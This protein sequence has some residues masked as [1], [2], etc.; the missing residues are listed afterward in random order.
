MSR[1]EVG[2]TTTTT[3]DD[4]FGP[5]G[6]SGGTTSGR[7]Q[8]ECRTDRYGAARMSACVIVSGA[9]HTHIGG[10]F[11]LP[12]LLKA[13]V[14]LRP[15]AFFFL[16]LSLHTRGRKR[17]SDVNVAQAHFSDSDVNVFGVCVLKGESYTQ[18]KCRARAAHSCASTI[19][20]KKGAR[21]FSQAP[22]NGGDLLAWKK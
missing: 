8:R 14:K 11:P 2:A 19:V 21:S 15:T 7:R 3:C 4:L 9:P 16:S 13:E 18:R 17:L 12:L 10:N 1:A 6:V 5:A 22:A 20:E